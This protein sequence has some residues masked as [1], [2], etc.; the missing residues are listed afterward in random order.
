M[1]YMKY[2]LLGLLML[3][4]M[5]VYQLKAMIAENFTAMC[6]DSMGSIQAA[7]KNLLS[8]GLITCTAVKE[9][10]VE[11][12]YYRIKENGRKEFLMW[13]QNPIDMSQGK[14]TELGKLLFMG[15]LPNDKR[16]ELISAVIKNLESELTYLKQILEVNKDIEANKK[17]LLDYYADNP[18]YAAALLSAG[19][20]KN[21]AQSFSD[22]HKYEM[23]TA[24]HGADLV[25]FHIKWFKELQKKINA[26]LF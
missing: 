25:Q 8:N 2:F 17:E 14:N 12:K 10:N 5:T 22:I 15:I 21:I 6:S 20:S 9:K 3:K 19:K 26:G 18:D 16:V 11:K 1:K 23:L 24:Q 4:E 13:L 7:L